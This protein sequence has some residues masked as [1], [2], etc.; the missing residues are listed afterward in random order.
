[1]RLFLIL[2]SIF[3][4]FWSCTSGGNASGSGEVPLP[5]FDSTSVKPAAA[6][7]ILQMPFEGEL[8]QAINWT[9]KG[10]KNT[11]VF[12]G[13]PAYPI[14]ADMRKAE[15][16]AYAFAAGENDSLALLWQIREAVDSCYCDCAVELTDS[17]VIL[18]DMD[19]DGYAEASF[20]YFLNNLCD[21]S[22]MDTKL[23]VASRNQT[24]FM[25][26]YTRRFLA[27]GKSFFQKISTSENFDQAS[28]PIR[29]FARLHWESYLQDEQSAFEEVQKG[30][31]QTE[32]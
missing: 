26:G 30:N 14:N 17:P 1:M 29:E 20:M 2:S 24:F 11:L 13:K 25:E 4:L 15:F 22:P 12:S 6:A 23:I 5:G 27:P 19:Q 10:G 3:G 7:E 8:I 18:R 9:D 28:P 31:K 32:D 16:F 21:A